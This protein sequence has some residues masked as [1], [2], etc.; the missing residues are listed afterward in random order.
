MK[1]ELL[2]FKSD[3]E[4]K[5]LSIGDYFRVNQE[6]SAFGNKCICKLIENNLADLAVLINNSVYLYDNFEG[7]KVV[8]VKPTKFENDILYFEEI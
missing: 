5:D 8:K 7:L 1:E 4:I 2:K 3:L 6:L